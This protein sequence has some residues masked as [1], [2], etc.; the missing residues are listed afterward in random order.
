MS[1]RHLTAWS[2]NAMDLSRRLVCP[3]IARMGLSRWCT[4]RK[5]GPGLPE[6]ARSQALHSQGGGRRAHLDDV[7]LLERAAAMGFVRAMQMPAFV[8]RWHA[9]KEDFPGFLPIMRPPLSVLHLII[10]G[11]MSNRKLKSWMLQRD[12]PLKTSCISLDG[13]S[14]TF[15]FL[16]DSKN[17]TNVNRLH[18]E[19]AHR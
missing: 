6:D 8:P 4:T 17:W 2:Y 14:G 16:Y 19:G 11:A 10:G 1:H 12:G 13:P 3:W 18:R 15:D 7:N 5:T 9:K